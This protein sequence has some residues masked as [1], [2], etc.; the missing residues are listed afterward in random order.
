M[1]THI[2]N[3]I[4][5]EINFWHSTFNIQLFSIS[6]TICFKSVCE[7]ILVS[8]FRISR[9]TNVSFIQSFDLSLPVRC[10][11]WRTK[12]KNEKIIHWTNIDSS[13][14]II[15]SGCCLLF[16]WNPRTVKKTN[17]ATQISFQFTVKSL[18]CL[19]SNIFS[20]RF[21]TYEVWKA[22]FT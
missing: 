11:K 10:S 1:C 18:K 16:F 14:V 12:I 15:T 13:H 7:L 6:Y 17:E 21:N 3:S 5:N 19:H 8:K 22:Y 20:I 4:E 9:N 2:Y